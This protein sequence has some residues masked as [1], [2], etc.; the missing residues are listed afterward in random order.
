MFFFVVIISHYI[1]QFTSIF[2]QLGKCLYKASITKS[3]VV[4]TFNSSQDYCNEIWTRFNRTASLPAFQ[5]TNITWAYFF[6]LADFT[7]Q[8]Y[9]NCLLVVIDYY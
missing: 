2:V 3:V 8:K 1:M 9:V 4:S 7:T 6:A 5:Q